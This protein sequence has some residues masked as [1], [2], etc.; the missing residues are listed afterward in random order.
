MEKQAYNDIFYSLNIEDIQSVSQKE[1]DRKLSDE[2]IASITELIALKIN[3][4][5]AIAEVINE[6]VKN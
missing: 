4:Y 3:W 1:I 5:D 6:H 2:E